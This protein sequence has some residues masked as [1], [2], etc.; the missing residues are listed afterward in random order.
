MFD[1]IDLEALEDVT[2]GGEG[3]LGLARVGLVGLQLATGN[4]EI[5]APRVEP[6]R[7]EQS[8][9]VPRVGVTQR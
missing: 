2:G 3:L 1:T 8:L 9:V 6:V 4:P 7:V 5:K